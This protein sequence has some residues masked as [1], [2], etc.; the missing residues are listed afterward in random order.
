MTAALPGAIRQ[1]FVIEGQEVRRGQPLATMV[2]RD[3]ME[4][5]GSRSRA[6]SRISLAKANLARTEALFKEGVIAGARVQEARAELAQAQSEAGEASRILAASGASGSGIVTLRAPISGRVS[7]VAVQTGGPVD[8]MTAPFVIDAANAYQLD[9]QLPERLAG[10]VR[11]GMTVSLPGAATGRI[12]S[13]GSSIDP[14][15]RSVVAKATIGSAQGVIAGKSVMVTIG[16][17]GSGE[18]VSVPST[19]VTRIAEKDVVFVRTGNRFQQREVRLGGS[20]NGESAILSGLKPG[21][22]VATSAIP[23]LKMLLGGGGE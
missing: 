10:N 3:A 8:G 16:A 19:A 13:V 12:L 14:A 15:T 21:E 6:S 22:V 4:L 2:S 17:G 23:E 9:L 5:G 11:P 1:V 18:V 20:G 7:K